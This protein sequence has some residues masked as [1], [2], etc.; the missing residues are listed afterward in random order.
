MVSGQIQQLQ[1]GDY[2]GEVELISL[3]NDEASPIVC[4]APVYIDANDGAKKAKANA[5]ATVPAVAL[6]VDTSISNAT[7]GNFQ[8]DGVLALTTGQWD[9][10]AGTTGGLTAG[11]VYYLSAATAGIIT[12]TAP[13][14]V[15]QYV[16]KI[17]IGISTT[18]MLIDIR[19][20]ILL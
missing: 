4:G 12:S 13:S 7:A 19:D 6:V 10:V 14:V 20:A 2:I 17:G 5:G 18:E 15:G 9:A 8:S 16:Q 3:T 1:S 11:T